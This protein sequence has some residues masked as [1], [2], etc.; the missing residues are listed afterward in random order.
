MSAA[1]KTAEIQQALAAVP[2]FPLPQIVLF[3]HALLPLHIFEP[4][5]RAMLKDCLAT[6]KTMALALLDETRESAPPDSANAPGATR[7][8]PIAAIAG[9]GVIIEHQPL[10]DGRSNIVLQGRAR[11]RLDELR[12]EPPYRRARGTLL[13][14]VTES[15]PPA[16]VAAL[17]AS[18]TAFAVEIRRH[19]PTFSFRVPENLDP[20]SLSD[21]CA[22]HFIVDT[23]LR[24]ELL[25]EL[26]PGER[27]R[28][29]TREL[30]AQHSALMRESGGLLH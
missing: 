12:F 21:Y 13:G 4:R 24:Q 17:V 14:D 29:V 27:I 8:P 5:Y 16:D 6:H 15:V 7:L 1:T 9:V 18:V 20:G 28:L 11:V 26:R 25:E 3:P 30:A 23:R 10:P 22:H 19:N 2:I